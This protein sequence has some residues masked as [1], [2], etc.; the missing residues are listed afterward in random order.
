MMEIQEPEQPSLISGAEYGG[1][2]GLVVV[3]RHW[4]PQS[5]ERA[6]HEDI[7]DEVLE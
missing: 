1:G 3:G 5:W 2:L 7:V 6:G 4:E